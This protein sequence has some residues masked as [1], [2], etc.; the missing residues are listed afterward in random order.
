MVDLLG[1]SEIVNTDQNLVYTISSGSRF[2]TP[3]PSQESPMPGD[4]AE[5][6]PNCVPG[7]KLTALLESQ[8]P[9]ALL[10]FAQGRRAAHSG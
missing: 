6:A 10:G 1:L 3:F 8:T 2:M 7:S 4:T 5:V 9:P